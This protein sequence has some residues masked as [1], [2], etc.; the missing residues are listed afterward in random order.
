MMINT[1]NLQNINLKLLYTVYLSYKINKDKILSLGIGVNN[2]IFDL[3]ICKFFNQFSISNANFS[4][5]M[6][7]DFT[8]K[9]LVTPIKL[10]H[11]L[12]I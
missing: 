12:Q 11:G 10:L 6:A 7:V 2:N 9:T 1:L 5:L 3:C 4:L 8:K